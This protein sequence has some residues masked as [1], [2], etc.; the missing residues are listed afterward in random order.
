[1]KSMTGYGSAEGA[2]GLGRVFVEVKG[3]NHRYSDIQLKIPPR[4]NSLDPR[5]RDTIK[6]FIERGKVELFLKE[7]REIAA[8]KNINVDIELARKYFSGVKRIQKEVGIRGDSAALFQMVDMGKFITLEDI[9][10]DYNRY[11]RQ[12]ESLV[13]KAMKKM[14]VMRKK[15]GAFILNDQRRRLGIIRGLV[16]KIASQA[17]TSVKKYQQEM[18]E[19]FEKAVSAVSIPQERVD[20][21]LVHLADKLDVSEE[22]TRLFSHLKQYEHILSGPGAV[23]RQLDFLLQEMNREINTI[24]SKASSAK[25][26][27]FVVSIKTELE[28]LREQ[29]QNLE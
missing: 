19:K 7:K 26:S 13:F 14:D 16:D 20:S 5:I 10:E 3:I 11:W 24:G 18:K 15:E 21:E 22:T 8:S 4:M 28:K 6:K 1:M 23:G 12:I 27:A 29:V 2:V 9:E 17:E 25:I